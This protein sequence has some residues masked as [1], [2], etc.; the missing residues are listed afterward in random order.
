MPGRDDLFP[1]NGPITAAARRRQQQAAHSIFH[2]FYQPS[3]G[4]RAKDVAR[5]VCRDALSGTSGR[6]LFRRVGM[7][8]ATRPSAIRFQ[9]S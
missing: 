7:N 8:A 5:L 4:L 9:P 1:C 6:R 2:I 3:T